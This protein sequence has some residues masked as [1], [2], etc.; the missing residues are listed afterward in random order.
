MGSI[1]HAPPVQRGMFVP[2]WLVM[3]MEMIATKKK[4]NKAY[5]THRGALRTPL[6]Y[7]TE[8]TFRLFSTEGYKANAAGYTVC[9]KQKKIA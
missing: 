3:A 5:A 7:P 1:T 4:S 2:R 6:A 8:R 9:I